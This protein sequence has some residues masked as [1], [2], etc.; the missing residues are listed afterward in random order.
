MVPLAGLIDVEAERT[1]LSKE[2]SK[3]EGGLKAVTAKL[4]NGKFVENAPEAV[5]AKE[6]EKQKQM[7]TT[8]S[9]LQAKMIELDSME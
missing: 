6:Q 3:L 5:V 8:L 7:T 9:A 2:I 4:S 1:R